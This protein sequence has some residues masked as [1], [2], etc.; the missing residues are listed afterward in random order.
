MSET[1]SAPGAL[2]RVCGVVVTFHPDISA[3]TRLLE[4][5]AP[6]VE[7]L[8]I[9]DNGSDT[10]LTSLKETFQA[11]LECL[12]KNYGI[13]RAQN[14]G[15][16][17]ARDLKAS[18]V[19]LLDQ[20]SLPAPDMVDQLIAAEH[21]LRAD[22]KK[23]AA[24]GANYV[25]PRQGETGSFVYRDG[26]RLKRRPMTAR[27]AIVE[28]D[29]LIASGSL[30]PIDVFDKV[31]DMVDE[32]FIDYVDIEWGLRARAMGYFS[33]GVFSAHMEH[34]LGDDHIPFRGHRVPLHSPLRHYYQLR[35]A[36][37]LIRQS[38]LPKVWT[39]LL[40]WRMFRQF[41][42]FTAAAPKGLKHGQMMI[43]GI[44]DGLRGRMGAK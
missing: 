5:I 27:D 13:A 35:N 20:D 19:L 22:G 41:L 31:G 16:K 15:I 37:W 23:V 2:P 34:A 43:A 3:L 24:V 33:Y 6:Q 30:T 36:V 28:T 7:S 32:L 1:P 11:Q 4:L 25:D 39:V 10:D 14:V 38:W 44:A 40:V 29:F 8:V 12:G 42:F 21:S 9:V 26:L 17:I 18:H